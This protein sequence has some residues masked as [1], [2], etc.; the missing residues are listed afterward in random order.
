[1]KGCPDICRNKSDGHYGYWKVMEGYMHRVEGDI[2]EWESD[3]AQEKEI[4]KKRGRR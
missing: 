1:M 3:K 2:R 4:K